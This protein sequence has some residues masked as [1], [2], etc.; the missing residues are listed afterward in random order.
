MTLHEL[1][2]QRAILLDEERITLRAFFQTKLATLD[3]RREVKHLQDVEK[4]LRKNCV[5]LEL[6]DQD[7]VGIVERFDVIA[8]TFWTYQN[9]PLP[10]YIAPE[11]PG[12]VQQQLLIA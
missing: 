2:E 4:R 12:I 10:A 5:A 3:R 1:L 11:L 7:F 6:E 8:K 9:I